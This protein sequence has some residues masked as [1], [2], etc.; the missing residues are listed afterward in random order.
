[1]ILLHSKFRRRLQ[2]QLFSVKLHIYDPAGK[3]VMVRYDEGKAAVFYELLDPGILVFTGIKMILGIIHIPT[4]ASI[5]FI[6]LAL[7]ASILASGVINKRT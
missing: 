6:V 3:S 2:R 4:I 7:T 5:G 1:M